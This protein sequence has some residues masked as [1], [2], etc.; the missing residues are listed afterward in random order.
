MMH[1]M[2]IT[3]IVLR[4]ILALCWV[5]SIVCMAV[6]AWQASEGL[7]LPNSFY[8]ALLSAGVVVFAPLFLVFS[9]LPFKE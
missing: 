7:N 1:G 5:G 3:M 4:T 9:Y 2:G 6:N 8:A